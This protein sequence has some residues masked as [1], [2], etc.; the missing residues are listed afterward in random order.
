MS[1]MTEQDGMWVDGR[2]CFFCREEVFAPALFW[3]GETDLL[4]HP[5]CFVQL[6]TR[7]FRDLHELERKHSRETLVVKNDR[8]PRK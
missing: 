5:T 4:L 3:M 2:P 6:A 8:G 7:L 1:V